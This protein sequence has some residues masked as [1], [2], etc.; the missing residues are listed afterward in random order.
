MSR[1]FAAPLRAMAVGLRRLARDASGVSAVEFALLAPVLLAMVFGIIEFG[2]VAYTQGVV[3]FAAEEAT[4]YAVVN[5]DISEEDVRDL[6][7][8][9]LLGIDPERINAIIVTGPVDPVDNTRTISVEVAY[10]FNFL[11]PFLP[12]GVITLS[13]ES[14]GF[15]IPPPLGAAPAVTGSALGCGRG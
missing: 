14:R 11:L 9:C 2:R 4:R 10:S 8:A 1:S 7:R 15:L 12:A 5:Y 13:G 3:S 6:A